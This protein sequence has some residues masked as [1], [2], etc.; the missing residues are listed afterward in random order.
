MTD[1]PGHGWRKPGANWEAKGTGP[2]LGGGGG[3]G[4]PRG[5]VWGRGEIDE[6]QP[7]LHL[8][9]IT[10]PSGWEGISQSSRPGTE[11][12]REREMGQR[13]RYSRRCV[14]AVCP[15]TASAEVCVSPSLANGDSGYTGAKVT[16]GNL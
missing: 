11:T 1:E 5:G 9:Q 8:S 7:Y 15:R 4:S 13:P 3:G 2:G 10:V 14:S 12:E 16:E 6:D